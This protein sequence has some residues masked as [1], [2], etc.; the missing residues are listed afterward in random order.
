MSLTENSK[1]H[2]LINQ[3]STII[4]QLRSI[5]IVEIRNLKLKDGHSSTEIHDKIINEFLI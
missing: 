4:K 3:K 1:C 2:Q 5:S